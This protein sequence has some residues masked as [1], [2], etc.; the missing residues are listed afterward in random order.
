M[1]KKCKDC[2]QTKNKSEFYG[3]QGECKE[4]TKARVRKRYY[5]PGI[6]ERIM[7]YER[8]R[9]RTPRRRKMEVE[10]YLKRKKEQPLK[11]KARYLLNKDLNLGR[12]K[13][14][15]CKLCGETMSE[16][17]HPDYH[18]PLWIVWLCRKH[19]YLIHKQPF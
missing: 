9:S 1:E 16:A 12:V 3:A 5:T 8:K 10:R 14:L 2:G 4:C 15:P 6:H 13:K 19:H 18:K 11:W 17:H 7:E